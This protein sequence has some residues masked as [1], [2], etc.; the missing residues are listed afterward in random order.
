MS[1]KLRHLWVTILL[2]IFVDK[3]KKKKLRFMYLVHRGALNPQGIVECKPEIALIV[4]LRPDK[5][6]LKAPV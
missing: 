2:N 3:T 5:H 4:S 6:F 1:P